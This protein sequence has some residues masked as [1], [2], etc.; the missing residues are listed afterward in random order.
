MRRL[1]A[2]GTVNGDTAVHVMQANLRAT[3]IQRGIQ[4]VS[5]WRTPGAAEIRVDAAAQILGT[6]IDSRPGGER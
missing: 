6:H 5:R 1:P 3:A 4:P 2:P